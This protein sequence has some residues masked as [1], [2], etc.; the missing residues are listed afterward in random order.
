MCIRDSGKCQSNG[1]TGNS[2]QNGTIVFGGSGGGAPSYMTGSNE[3]D[4]F[5]PVVNI[6]VSSEGV[7]FSNGAGGSNGGS[8]PAPGGPGGIYVRFGRGIN[9]STAPGSG[10]DY[11]ISNPTYGVPDA[12]KLLDI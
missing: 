6:P 2:S 1:S 10:N 4:N 7:N 9:A 3:P 11:G 5:V 8:Q 12:A